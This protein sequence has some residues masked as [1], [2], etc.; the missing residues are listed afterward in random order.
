MVAVSVVAAGY[1]AA[2]ALADWDPGDRHKMHYP[3]LPDPDGWDVEADFNSGTIVADDRMCSRTGPINDIHLWGSWHG[4]MLDTIDGVHVSIHEGIPDPDGSGPLFSMPGQL[5]WE[6]DVGIG[7][8][9]VR[10]YGTGDQGWYAPHN[11]WWLRPDH[12]QY[13]QINLVD[14]FDPFLQ[15]EG[16]IYW[17][18]IQILHPTFGTWWGWKTSIEHWNDDAVWWEP[19]L[20]EWR[21]LRDPI[22]GESL[23]MAFV[24]TPEPNALALLALGGLLSRR[25]RSEAS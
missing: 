5:L 11:D 3:Q 19:N 14:I 2:P 21:E 4:D 8:F 16:T 1:I 9:T 25:R 6:R 20:M 15:E 12:F 10:D 13:H 18:D 24:I 23:D 7:E 22:T 17:L